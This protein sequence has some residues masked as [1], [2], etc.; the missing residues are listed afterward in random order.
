MRWS[1]GSPESVGISSSALLDF[2]NGLE[3]F[4]FV[5]S[6]LLLRNGI[7]A[8]SGWWAPYDPETPHLLFSLSKSFISCAI[9]IAIGEK[10]LTLDTL[11]LDIFPEYKRHVTDP[12]YERMTIRHLLTMASGHGVCSTSFF[13]NH[14]DLL[15]AFF[16]SPLK[17]EPGEHFVYNSGATFVLSA[18]IRRLTGENPVDYLRERF[19]RPLGIADRS[20]E[21]SPDGT[22]FGGWGY[23]LTTR[24]IASF[25]LMLLEHGRC[26]GKQLIPETYLAEATAF[27]IDN[28]S[29]EALD[30]KQGYGFQFWRCRHNAFRGDGAFGQY[31]LVIPEKSLA[32]AITSGG[33]NMQQIL[34]V[35]WDKL[36]PNLQESPLPE[37]PA[38]WTALQKKLFSLSLPVLHG[39]PPRRKSKLLV[40]LEENPLKLQNVEIQL[41]PENCQIIFSRNGQKETL[42]AGWEKPERGFTSLEDNEERPYSATAEISGKTLKLRVYFYSTPYVSE[43]IFTVEKE[44]LTFCRERNLHFL[45]TPWPQITGYLKSGSDQVF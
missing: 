16:T 5:H 7:E 39:Q 40:D 15:L 36:L 4:E 26:N 10:R 6:F 8:A 19:L 22:D 33:K 43:Y 27:Q 30:W 25:A 44:R 38:A 34:D 20:W 17:F 3:K 21:K 41:S 14:T 18:A 12:R 24:E 29:N 9:G 1:K 45:T 13:K 31:A 42:S 35:V 2:V 37:D 23:R 32:L 28:S 11:L